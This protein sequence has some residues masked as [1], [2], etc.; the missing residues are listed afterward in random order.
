MTNWQPSSRVFG[1]KTKI[2]L[3]RQAV[4]ANPN[5]GMAHYALALE[6]FRI[7]ET[8]AGLDAFKRAMALLRP[9][10]DQLVIYVKA[11][12]AQGHAREALT[13]LNNHE[14]GSSLSPELLTQRGAAL[15]ALGQ[16]DKAAE[17]LFAAI[18]RDPDSIDT[19]QAIL[20]VLKELKDWSHLMRFFEEQVQRNGVTIP[21][22]LA[23]IDGLMGLGRTEEA[24]RLLDFDSFVSVK[25]IDP[26]PSF[27]DL[28]EFNTALASDI[29]GPKKVR[30]SDAPRL[31][32]TGGVQV[33]DL[34]VGSSTAMS[35]LFEIIRHAVDEYI[36]SRTGDSAKLMQQLSPEA[37]SL[38][39]WGLMLG[40][41]DTQDAH[42]H[43]YSSVAGVYYVA[44]PEAL[45]LSDNQDGCLVIPSE[46]SIA[47]H[48]LPPGRFLK[49]IP[50]R[51]VLF[52]GYFPH[53]TMPI[54][55]DG[56][57][58][59]IAFDIVPSRHAGIDSD[60]DTGNFYGSS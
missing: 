51:L 22:V 30:L 28:S 34:E 36:A 52:P 33:E 47:G 48:S 41:N 57:R 10:P 60:I 55:C 20:L 11:L 58:I 31:R 4:A 14:K 38:E 43:L 18:E 53:R 15:L 29:T 26:P 37:A 16:A 8:V 32:L 25:M 46:I 13:V 42:W 44:A 6:L 23:R 17:F 7:E 54:R 2:M 35:C 56:D 3:A 45:F 12:L 24:A 1:A 9:T 21:V 5:A 39:C 49:P 40:F 50:G 19:A 59:S 27:Q